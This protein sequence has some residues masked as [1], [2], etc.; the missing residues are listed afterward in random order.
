MDIPE[1]PNVSKSAIAY[2]LQAMEELANEQDFKP[3]DEAQMKK[4]MDENSQAIVQRSQDL[5]QEFFVKF[6]E[7]QEP[8]VKIL[9]VNMW[10]K[11]RRRETDRQ[12]KQYID[13][14]LR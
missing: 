6:Q 1:F 12:L 10:G 11:V 13:D 2:L 9:A 4:W 7:H 14:A 8:I 5:Q 3:D